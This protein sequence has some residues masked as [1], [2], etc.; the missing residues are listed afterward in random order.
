LL[1][2]LGSSQPVELRTTMDELI[3]G[4]DIDQFGSAPTKFD[5]DDLYPLTARFNQTLTLDAVAEQIAALGVPADHA[6]RFWDVARENI[7]V[8]SDLSEWADL[9]KNGADPLIDAGDE[10]FI[11]QA[12]KM[13]PDGPYTDAIWGD[14]TSAVKA[15]TGR[16]RFAL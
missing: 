7:T 11:A 12:M 3:E 10:E 1:A 15:E 8:L 14:W 2:R 9:A 5:V 16:N 6:A 13:L 4:F